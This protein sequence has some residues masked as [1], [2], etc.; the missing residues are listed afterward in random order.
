MKKTVLAKSD[1]PLMECLINEDWMD[2]ENLCQILVGRQSSV[3]EVAYSF[4][5]VDL[6][7]LGV[8]NADYGKGMEMYQMIKQGMGSTQEMVPCA[9]DVVAKI[10]TEAVQYARKWGFE[11]NKDYFKAKELLRGVRPAEI[12]VPTGGPGGKPMYMP[13]PHDN[14][15]R[16]IATLERTAGEGNYDYLLPI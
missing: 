12:G 9:I 7:C 11:P 3:G 10:L 5:L 4:F 1:W 13:G 8:K 15:R 6:A 14:V 2:T 16:I